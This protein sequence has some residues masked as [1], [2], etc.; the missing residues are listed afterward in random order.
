MANSNNFNQIALEVFQVAIADLLGENLL[1]ICKLNSEENAIIQK[2]R[3]LLGLNREVNTLSLLFD[4]VKLPDGEG[5]NQD[6]YVPLREIVSNAEGYPKIPYPIAEQPKDLQKYRTDIAKEINPYLSSDRWNDL[7]FLTFIL[8]KY[9]SCVSYGEPYTALID[10]ARMTAAVAV[11]LSQN[12]ESGAE[13]KFHLVAGSLSGIQKFIY[14]ISSDGALKSLRARSFYLELVAEEIVQQIL[15]ELKLPRTN[16]IYAGGGNLFILAS[17]SNNSLKSKL[18]NLRN[19]F[20]KWLEE[21]F[22]GKIFLSLACSS[23]NR[24]DVKSSSFGNCWKNVISELAKQKSQKFSHQIK[25]GKLL[26]IKPSYQPCKVCHRDDVKAERLKSLHE[27]SDVLACPTCR[28]MFRLGGQLFRTKAILRSQRPK[29]PSALDRVE[30]LGQ[31]YYLFERLPELQEIECNDK[32]ILVNDFDVNHYH[33]SNCNLL[34]LGN[35][36][37]QGE[38][39]FMRAEEMT[40]K[41]KDSGCIPRVG[42]LRMDVDRLGQIFAKGLPNKEDSPRNID[43]YSLPRVASL[44]RQMSYFFKVY[45]NSL[46]SDRANNLPEKVETLT[47]KS[48]KNFSRC[49][50]MFIYAGGDDLFISGA[51]NEVVEFAFDIYQSFRAYT[52]NHPDITI[53]GGI[54]IDDAKFPLYQSADSSKHAEDKAKANN[55]DSLGL[56]GEAFKWEEWLGMEN[57]Q[58]ENISS[59]KKAWEYIKTKEE[60]KLFGVLAIAKAIQNLLKSDAQVSRNFTRN[61][62]ATAQIQ[63]Q[64]IEEFEDK[65]TVKQYENQDKDIRYFLHLPK[66]AYTLSRLPDR[67]RGNPEFSKISTSLKSPYNAPYFRAIATWIELL[68]RGGTNQ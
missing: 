28:K 36:S 43:E 59:L 54:S 45:L 46:A 17:D 34:L 8:E 2:A 65:R 3:D 5:A 57:I 66:I 13:E 67:I 62:L 10:A 47:T 40:E 53:S 6:H 56:F 32:L 30:I 64:K 50:L 4:R 60:L 31:K 1:D 24:N 58:A 68:N 41:A 23:C 27:V 37:Q 12:Q 39:G 38:E 14:T 18:E 44:S 35:Y 11:A 15:D 20:N 63:E 21:R 25:N 61:L 9:G 19:R 26:D 55:R 29:I 7:S 51:W 52:G 33:Y 48:D 49:N 22:K 16:V 42:Y